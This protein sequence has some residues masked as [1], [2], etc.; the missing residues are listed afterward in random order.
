MDYMY[1]PRVCI[2]I[3]DS[4]K[5]I[6]Y[7]LENLSEIRDRTILKLFEAD[8]SGRGPSG[9]GPSGLP[10]ITNADEE[11]AAVV[12]LQQQPTVVWERHPKTLLNDVDHK[13]VHLDN[14]QRNRHQRIFWAHMFSSAFQ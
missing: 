9:L 3:H 8:N 7:E 13:K 10:P 11:A 1:T 4:S 14:L 6:F 2:Y 5:D 12:P